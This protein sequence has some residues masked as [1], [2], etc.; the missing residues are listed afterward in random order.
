[1]T[2]TVPAVQPRRPQRAHLA[3]SDP[4]SDAPG[5]NAAAPARGAA[6]DNNYWLA[7][8]DG[9]RVDSVG[10]RI[11]FVDQVDVELGRVVLRVR[12]G[13]LGRRI[14]SINADDVAFIVPRAQ[15]IWLSSRVS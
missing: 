10:G 6:L 15:R 8:C 9:Y 13:R 12:L 7:H 5:A 2:T 14:L 4:P 3:L 11:G 1:M